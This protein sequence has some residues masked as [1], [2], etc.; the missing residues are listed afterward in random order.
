MLFIAWRIANAPVRGQGPDSSPVGY[1]AAIAFQFVNPK[2]WLIAVSASAT[3]STGL[4]QS[5]GTHGAWLVAARLAGL[6]FCA[7]IVCGLCWVAVGVTAAR[8]L[9]SARSQRLFNIS[10][11]ALLALSVVLALT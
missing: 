7:A 6:F 2:A 8:L 4:A 1:L 9:E 3:Y 5:T 10:M 11:G